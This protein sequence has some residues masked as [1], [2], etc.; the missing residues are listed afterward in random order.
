MLRATAA[1]ALLGCA[2]CGAPAGPPQAPPPDVV[3]VV[4]DTLRADHLGFDGYRR[5]TSP[6]LDRLAAGS[7]VFTQARAQAPCTAPSV[8][9]LLTSR[10]PWDFAGRPFG[11]LGIPRGMPTVAG[12]LRRAGYRTAAV[13]ASP[14]VRATPG[15]I[16]REGG[17][18][19]GFDLFLEGCERRDARCVGR[20]AEDLL[21]LLPR[22]F[23]LY[24]HYFDP[25]DPYAAPDG[26]PRRFATPYA[27][28]DEA[29]AAGDPLP[30]VRRLHERG[31]AGLGAGDLAH[32][33]DLY[34][35]EIAYVDHGIGELIA[36]LDLDR[37]L[38]VVTSDHGES[39]LEHGHLQHCRSLYDP[40]LRVPLLVRPPGGSAPRRVDTPVAL[41]DVT[42]TLLDY[43]GVEKANGMAG[44]SL[45]PAVEGRSL[46]T[47]PATAAMTTRRSLVEGRW[48]LIHDLETGGTELYDLPSDPAERANLLA[49]RP[50]VTN[51]LLAFLDRH[52]RAVE[53]EGLEATDERLEKG[54]EEERRL[55]AL[56]YL[57]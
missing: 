29:V 25:H 54:R 35:E 26:A 5:P 15:E 31:D 39:F 38:L 11:H 20:R 49:E 9:S 24:L 1:L 4:V 34:D 44:R 23:F 53:G 41:L 55:R 6:H 51:R 17:F 47:R 48:K 22:P 8:N 50:R 3:L 13:S 18:G 36:R 12:L 28:S 7:S 10:H 2:A 56:G 27:G 57:P 52:L 42:P 43:A 33:V 46:R 19:H 14:V 16:N 40:E 37:T 30:A 21:G 45:R 32:L